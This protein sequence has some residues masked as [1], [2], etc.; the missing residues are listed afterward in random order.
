MNLEISD[1]DNLKVGQVADIY[2]IVPQSPNGQSHVIRDVVEIVSTGNNPEPWIVVKSSEAA[3]A[4]IFAIL[5]PF[6]TFMVSQPDKT[7]RIAKRIITVLKPEHRNPSFFEQ[8]IKEK[9]ELIRVKRFLTN[10]PEIGKN[11]P[12]SEIYNKATKSLWILRATYSEDLRAEQPT[13][14]TRLMKTKVDLEVNLSIMDPLIVMKELAKNEIDLLYLPYE[15]GG[16]ITRCMIQNA[17]KRTSYEKFLYPWELDYCRKLNDSYAALSLIMIEAE[18]NGLLDRLHLFTSNDIGLRASFVKGQESIVDLL[19]FIKGWTGMS[20]NIF[21]C[22]GGENSFAGEIVNLAEKQLDSCV[23]SERYLID[24]IR[25]TLSESLSLYGL[26]TQSIKKY[27]ANP[28]DL[29]VIRDGWDEL[30]QK[31]KDKSSNYKERISFLQN[32][33]K[34]TGTDANTFIVPFA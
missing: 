3:W 32:L 7:V 27:L 9:R 33:G 28:H 13:E 30:N 4:L 18:Q 14:I 12:T 15:E 24:K 8:F 29:Q 23:S 1:V 6:I 34:D 2:Y 16:W 21:R 25:D 26:L 22:N 17:Y 20:G 31:L 5:V 11:P 10:Y 19:Y